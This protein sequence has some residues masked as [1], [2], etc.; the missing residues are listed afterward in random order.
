MTAKADKGKTMVK[1]HELKQKIDTFIQENRIIPWNKD[2]TDS[3]QKHIQQTM[4]RYNTIDENQHKYLV[5]IKPMVPKLNALI[6][7][8]KD[9][10]IGPDK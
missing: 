3:F 2:S 1:I 9:T 8:N 5:R 7:T 10:P 6:K 4:H